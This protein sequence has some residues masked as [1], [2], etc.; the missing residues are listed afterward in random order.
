MSHVC[1]S[2]TVADLTP[3]LPRQDAVRARLAVVALAASAF[4][5]VTAEVLPVG[6]LP[7]ISGSLGVSEGRVGFL[8]T[9]Y[10]ALAGLSAIPLTVRTSR[11]ARDRLLVILMSIFTGST[12]LAAL[13]PTY[14]L[15]AASRLRLR[16]GA[17]GVL[18][19][20]RSDG[21]SHR[22]ECTG[23]PVGLLRLHGYRRSRPSSVSRSA[24]SSG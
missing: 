5:F 23:G 21:W 9:L 7:Q 4:I 11:V 18:G 2:D 24:R 19:H 15:L 17:R 13:A 20:P 14:G 6:L 22:R 10:A 12:V 16:P 1:E 3:I 8:L